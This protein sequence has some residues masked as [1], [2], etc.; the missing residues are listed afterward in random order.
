M[1]RSS[2]RVG[3][4][5]D[6]ERILVDHAY[7]GV[8]LQVTVR[9]ILVAF[10]ALTLL[11]VPPA[12]D[13]VL[14]AVIFTCY[15]VWAAA[16]A[17]WMRPGGR[18]PVESSWLALFADLAVV[19][20]LTLVTGIAAQQSWT[21]D[22]LLNGLFLIPLLAGTQLRPGVCAA[23]VAPTVAAF[24]AAS[25]ATKESNAE[26]WSSILLS[27]LALA[28][29]GAGA[30][31]LSAIQ[32]SRVR[33]IGTLVGERTALLTD[34][35]GVEQRERQALAERLHDGALQYVLVA[36]QDLDDVR[37][38]RI[39]ALDRVD[40]ALRETSTLLR[41]ATTELHPAV[42]DHLGLAPALTDLARWAAARGRFDCAVYT[43]DWPDD[44]RTSVD[45]MLFGAARELLTNV[46][47]HARADTVRMRL[48]WTGATAR[49]D[50]V[51]D[52]IGVPD[53]AWTPGLGEGHIGLA[54]HRLRIAAAG[55]DLTVARGRRAG[56]V[57]RVEVPAVV[58]RA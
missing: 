45:E 3:T 13:A 32:R 56:T 53:G 48:G 52:G 44:M 19:A 47:K 49:L 16:T 9:V 7:R 20:T 8:R 17:V 15:V 14:C 46:V 39:D 43:D 21:S 23:V 54:S 35:M 10:I 27:T 26:P 34:L 31:G 33:T 6:L 12:G 36:R 42:L 5:P 37:D 22:V 41:G 38:G 24:L 18:I 50:V 40:E 2:A 28:G 51:D 30:V 11:F 57:A 4:G 55:G 58:C 25:W 29:L 1:S